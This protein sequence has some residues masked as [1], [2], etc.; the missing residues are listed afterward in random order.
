MGN[1]LTDQTRSAL[2]EDITFAVKQ[3]AAK[4]GKMILKRGSDCLCH[5]T[6]GNLIL[7]Q[8]AAKARQF[9]NDQ[10]NELISE[11]LSSSLKHGWKLGG[12]PDIPSNGL[13]MGSSGIA[14]G[15][16]HLACPADTDFNP[17]LLGI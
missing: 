12:L 8:R 7:L 9:D 4:T 17:F 16:A 3:L 15:L 14:W 6:I 10:L 1:S 2:Y 5:G 11:M 13:M